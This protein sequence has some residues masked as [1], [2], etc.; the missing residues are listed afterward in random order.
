VRKLAP[1]AQQISRRAALAGLV[2]AAVAPLSF[3][4]KSDPRPVG[5]AVLGLG[6][7]ATHEIMP[8]FVHCQ[9]SKLVAL[10]SGHP[11]K[12]VRFGELY[13]IPSSNRY[14]YETMDAILSN[15]EIDVVYVITPP[16][17]HP[18]FVVRAAG[19]GK[20]VCSEKPMAPTV[21][22]CQR[23]IDACRHHRKL[24]QVGYRCHY[25][26][27]NLRAIQACRS[28]ELGKIQS[29]RSDHGFN[30]GTGQWRTQKLLAGGGSMMDIGIYSLNALRYLSGEEPLEVTATITN[31]PNDPRFVDVEDTVDFTLRFPSG[32]VGHGT[33]GYSWRQGKNRYEVVGEKGTLLAEPATAYDGDRLTL[34]GQELPVVA[35]NQFA[36]Q[37]DHFSQCVR[38]RGKVR[39]PGEEG[40]QD[41]RI[42]QAIY[43][44]AAT[45]RPV[46]LT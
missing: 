33:S 35:T 1:M 6:G 38:G 20:H 46:P 31:P 39:T 13:G 5:W 45:G 34:N 37:I 14:T 30:I 15:P 18:N 11:D 41:I 16:A 23:M 10:I 12:L 7:Y 36:A 4:V 17:T 29:L 9:N 43:D 8:S 32:L 27:H 25:E 40:R 42:I 3:A 24:L 21:A 26:A 28:G 2:G 22:E 19:L 44:S